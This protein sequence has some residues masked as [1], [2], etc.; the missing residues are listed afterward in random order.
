MIRNKVEI[1]THAVNESTLKFTAETDTEK[2]ACINEEFKK[3]YLELNSIWDSNSIL[4]IKAHR[5]RRFLHEFNNYRFE[6]SSELTD[7]PIKITNAFMKMY[8]FLLFMTPVLTKF[9]SIKHYDIASAPGMFILAAYEYFKKR[10]I[11]YDWRATSRENID[12]GDLCDEYELFRNNPQKYSAVDVC[13]EEDIK[14][15]ISKHK[16]S[17]EL[18]SGDIGIDFNKDYSNY[19]LLEHQL[20]DQQWGQ[21]RLAIE[22]C[23]QGGVIFLKMFTYTSMQTH[24]LVDTVS[25]YFDKVYIVK[26][27]T[28]KLMSEESYLIGIGR[29]SKDCNKVK[30]LRQKI[31]E[32][33]SKNIECF[34]EFEQERYISRRDV[35]EF[36]KYMIENHKFTKD[37]FYTTEIYK[38]YFKENDLLIDLFT[39]KLKDNHILNQ[40]MYKGG[41]RSRCKSR[42]THKNKSVKRNR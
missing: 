2:I 25:E 34:N 42:S 4:Q 17:F 1:T 5:I 38:K 18:V 9:D 41:G 15:E 21:A 7:K 31:S 23:K 8:E 22:L 32:Y 39:L 26:P 36:V 30:L 20:P 11:K 10:N 29:N 33:I 12:A 37:F 40:Y 16:G 35:I 14:N 19:T 27:R 6:I 24:Y 13:S 28:S 3:R